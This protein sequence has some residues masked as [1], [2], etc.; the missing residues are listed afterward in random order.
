MN[1]IG[2]L[3]I[4]LKI[5]IC[6][7]YQ[8]HHQSLFLSSL[9]LLMSSAAAT[10]DGTTYTGKWTFSILKWDYH[11][12]WST[13]LWITI[14]DLFIISFH[15]IIMSIVITSYQFQDPIAQLFILTILF[16]L[17][18]CP[19]HFLSSLSLSFTYSL[20]LACSLF[21]IFLSFS[22][23]PPFV[24]PTSIPSPSSPLLY[25]SSS[26]SLFLSHLPSLSFSFLLSH[27]LYHP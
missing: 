5:I 4:T 16:F 14:K 10:A 13:T 7:H 17:Y 26:I 25:L 8:Y 2:F 18:S 20:F 19:S 9:S 6:H 27:F 11:M 1:I 24:N 22:F 21:P 23:T 12:V 3:I 15:I